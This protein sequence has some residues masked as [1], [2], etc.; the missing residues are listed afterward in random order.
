MEDPQTS[1]NA[2]LGASVVRNLQ[3]RGFAAYYCA[4]KAAALSQALALI[5]KT[6]RVSWGGSVSIQE[7]GLLA[8]VRAEYQTID[9]D[10]A[11]SPAE[12]TAIMRQGL[13]ADTF[14]MSANA[15]SADGQLVNID[16]NGNRCAA[17]IFG[18]KQVLVIAGI[19][20]LAADVQQA[21]DRARFQAAPT[22]MRRFPQKKTPCQLTG[23]CAD[24]QSPDSICNYF[25]ITRRCFPPGKIKVIL[26]GES[27]GY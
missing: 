14:L 21:M 6:D 1:R 16:G 10:K 22:N 19:N 13:L 11:A 5:P 23:C 3:Q 20:K 24:C 27:L 17:L 8:K 12:K 7:I 18:P 2:S 15:I 9:R 4:D 25:V 26:V